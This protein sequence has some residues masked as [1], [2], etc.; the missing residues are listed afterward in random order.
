VALLGA[1]CS[2]ELWTGDCKWHGIRFVLAIPPNWRKGVLYRRHLCNKLVVDARMLTDGR[3]WW[4]ATG[5]DV[6]LE[7]LRGA[8]APMG[9]HGDRRQYCP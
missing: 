1:S 4:I 7:K 5:R 9:I 8:L 3:W 6:D 2:I